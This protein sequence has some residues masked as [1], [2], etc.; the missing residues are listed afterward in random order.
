MRATKADWPE[1]PGCGKHSCLRRGEILAYVFLKKDKMNVKE[2]S[3]FVDESG[4]FA[5]A[6]ADPVAP[7]YLLCMVFHNQADDISEEVDRLAGAL[8]GIGLSRSH[9]VH[10]GPL[11]R[12]EDE[13]EGMSRQLRIGIFR[14]MM[15]FFQRAC[16]RYRCFRIYKPYNSRE[17]AIHDVIL[18][19]IVNFLVV[20]REDFNLCD[21]IKVYYDNGQTQVTS[22][23]KEA[24]AMFSSKTVFV[25]DVV[26]SRYRLFQVADVACT[27]ELVKAKLLE[28]GSLTE[29]EDRFFGG[30]RNLKK[31]YLKP[32][33]RKVYA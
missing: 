14:R 22:L 15:V 1:S 11:I 18:Q 9:T 23:L 31:N 12:R 25:P 19:D 26:P 17:N 8:E 10:A 33:A 2:I 24:F 21:C 7:F 4:S 29:S 16:F 28:T 13:Y 32:L 20:H 3:V 27:L 6:E 30:I 5:P